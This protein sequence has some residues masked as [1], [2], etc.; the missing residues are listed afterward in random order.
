MEAKLFFAAWSSWST[1][2]APSGRRL[3]RMRKEWRVCYTSES[4]WTLGGESDKVLGYY[5][6]EWWARFWAGVQFASDNV[7]AC[8]LEHYENGKW[9]EV[10]G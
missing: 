10:Q 6:S 4:R 3:G 8:W 2:T 9:V 5:Q 7:S 1:G